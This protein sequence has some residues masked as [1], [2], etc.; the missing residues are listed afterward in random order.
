VKE[1]RRDILHLYLV[2]VLKSDVF[3][4]YVAVLG[5]PALA[6]EERINNI[7]LLYLEQPYVHLS[8]LSTLP[9]NIKFLKYLIT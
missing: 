6:M 1:R 4:S 2:K 5:L 7:K 8:T 3:I 9:G